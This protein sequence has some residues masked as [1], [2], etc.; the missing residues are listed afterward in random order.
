MVSDRV[1]D[2]HW[3]PEMMILCLSLRPDHNAFPAL[4]EPLH[5]G[6]LTVGGMVISADKI[7]NQV[8]WL[9]NER[10]E[11]EHLTRAKLVTAASFRI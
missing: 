2:R 5:F 8:K 1:S 4:T 7:G 6:Y 10:W 3:L 9:K 11:A